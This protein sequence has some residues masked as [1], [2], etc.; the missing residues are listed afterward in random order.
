[1]TSWKILSGLLLMCFLNSP[2]WFRPIIKAS[3]QLK[4]HLNRIL[5]L[6]TFPSFATNP[7][8]RRKKEKQETSVRVGAFF[9]CS[10]Y[11][12]SVSMLRSA[13]VNVNNSQGQPPPKRPPTDRCRGYHNERNIRH[14]LSAMPNPPHRKHKHTQL[15]WPDPN[16]SFLPT[17]PSFVPIPYV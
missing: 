3:F 16:L 11:I 8:D 9:L 12:S 2:F 13:G 17:L 4:A 6:A 10:A 5:P 14:H 7:H 1:M 15:L